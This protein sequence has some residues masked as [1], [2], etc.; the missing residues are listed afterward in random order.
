MKLAFYKGTQ[1][2]LAGLYNRLARLWLRGK[3][4]HYEVIFSDKMCASSAF[5]NN[6]IHFK[7][8]HLD[9]YKW[10]IIFVDVDERRVRDWFDAR[11]GLKYD[12]FGAMGLVLRV[13]GGS[14]NRY[15]CSEALMASL[16][17]RDS[18]RYDP[19]IAFSTLKGSS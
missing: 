6:K 1:K 4:T 14:R 12:L 8:I 16:G 17:Y 19:C 18:W 7:K 3:Y 15:F 13:F 9:P 10:D 5:T 11:A 2:G